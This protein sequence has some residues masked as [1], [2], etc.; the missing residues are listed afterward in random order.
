MRFCS[1]AN[2]PSSPLKS[3]KL[4]KQPN[5]FS[6]QTLSSLPLSFLSKLHSHPKSS[7]LFPSDFF[8]HLKKVSNGLPKSSCSC[9]TTPP[10]IS[11]LTEN[12][13]SSLTARISPCHVSNSHSL[14]NSTICFYDHQPRGDTWPHGTVTLGKTGCL[15]DEAP[16]GGLQMETRVVI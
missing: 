10:K 4:L 3:T 15:R 11:L 5:L 1:P 6:H 12:I 9:Q 2:T 8:P 13:R 7:P 16:N 14:L